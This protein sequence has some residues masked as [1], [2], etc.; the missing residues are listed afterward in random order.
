MIHAVLVARNPKET[1]VNVARALQVLPA[2]LHWMT[3]GDEVLD[4][5]EKSADRNDPVHLVI[6]DEA[7][8]DMS[9]R[10]LV[11]QVVMKNPIINCM[12]LSGLTA[13]PF[14]D[15]YEGLGVLMPLPLAPT[16]ED[17]ETMVATLKKVL[18]L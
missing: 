1:F 2:T 7:L 8:D 5:I 15:L 10:A 12:A 16:K 14:H 6:T 3:R 4:H 18:P 13:K 11:E 9:G 17:G